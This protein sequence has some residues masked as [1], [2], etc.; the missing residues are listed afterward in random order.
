MNLIMLHLTGTVIQGPH[1][2]FVDI[3]SWSNLANIIFS[4]F[5]ALQALQ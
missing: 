1:E 3:I 2:Q 4:S 5:L